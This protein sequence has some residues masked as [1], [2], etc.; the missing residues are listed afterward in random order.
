MNALSH[1]TSRD[2]PVVLEPGRSP[3]QDGTH[4]VLVE[5]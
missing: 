4:A 3:E 1:A 5:Q 2:Y